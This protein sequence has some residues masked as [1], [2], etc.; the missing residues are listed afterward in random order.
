MSTNLL[1]RIEGL[2]L[3]KGVKMNDKTL[4][5]GTFLQKKIREIDY[6][7]WKLNHTPRMRIKAKTPSI[8]FGNIAYGAM[9]ETEMECDS[10]LKE[11]IIKVVEEHKKELE[12]EFGEL[13]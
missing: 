3:Q 11:K 10:K 7:L 9:D 1:A 5:R 4:Q 13:K 2:Y 12:K 8:L 6:V